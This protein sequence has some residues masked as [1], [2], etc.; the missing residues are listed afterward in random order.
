MPSMFES[1]YVNATWLVLRYGATRVETVVFSSDFPM[2]KGKWCSE[3]R[4]SRV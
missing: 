4:G 3:H 1:A 2:L